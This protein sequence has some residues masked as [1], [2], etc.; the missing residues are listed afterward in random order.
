MG[1][2]RGRNEETLYLW[3]DKLR[4]ILLAEPIVQYSTPPPLI[5]PPSP[6]P[7]PLPSSS[8]WLSKRS[9]GERERWSFLGRSY[10]VRRGGKLG[11]NGYISGSQPFSN[12]DPLFDPPTQ[13]ISR[14]TLH[15]PDYHANPINICTLFCL[16]AL[17]RPS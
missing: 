1:G 8:L 4:T 7:L 15:V 11:G 6:S 3:V 14:P 9:V 10:G 5:S 17:P 12:R 13:S 2:S 16:K